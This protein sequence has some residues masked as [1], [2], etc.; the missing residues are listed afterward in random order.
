LSWDLVLAPE[1]IKT[2]SYC[3]NSE[4][5]G[6]HRVPQAHAYSD[7]CGKLCTESSDSENIITVYENISY[8]EYHNKTLTEV[9]LPSGADLSAYL[10]KNGYSLL[11][12]RVENKLL[13]ASVFIPAGTRLLDRQK[14]PLKTIAIEE[15]EQPSLPGSLIP[16]GK[17]YGLEPEG[18][19][20]DPFASISLGLESS[21]DKSSPAVYCYNGDNSTWTLFES[22]LNE[23]RISA[24]IT[25]FSIYTVLAEPQKEVKLKVK[26]VP[27]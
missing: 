5:P 19:E 7:L 1:E 15:A 10:D 22:T 13:D 24:E 14:E 2:F 3:I 4:Q 26:V 23:R 20:F 25:D 18:A 11:D 16:V 27:P 21:I 12:I 8:I 6:A 17:C 9:I